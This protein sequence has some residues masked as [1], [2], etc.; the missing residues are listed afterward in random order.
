MIVE[1]LNSP[2]QKLVKEILRSV[3]ET[4]M[5]G[6]LLTSAAANMMAAARAASLGREAK[7]D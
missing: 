2:A 5:I 7:R 3:N 4:F 6:R 1:V